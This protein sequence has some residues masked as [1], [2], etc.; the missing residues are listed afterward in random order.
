MKIMSIL[1]LYNLLRKNKETDS[2]D[3]K[4]AF[5]N[6]IF[7]QK[8]HTHALVDSGAKC[9]CI[10][11]DAFLKIPRSMIKGKAHRRKITLRSAGGNTLDVVGHY[12]L[13]FFIENREYEL[14]FAVVKNLTSEVLL[15]N[16][17]IVS[18]KVSI[19]GDGIGAVKV[20]IAHVS[21]TLDNDQ[22]GV[23]AVE[24]KDIPAYSIRPVK[25]K[26]ADKQD[27]KDREFTIFQTNEYNIEEMI[28]KL[29]AHGNTILMVIN[30]N[31]H[32]IRIQRN[33]KV[34]EAETWDEKHAARILQ[35][36]E[37][38][39][40][41]SISNKNI[42][43]KDIEKRWKLIAPLIDMTDI[44]KEQQKQYNKLFKEFVD[45]FSTNKFDLGKTTTIE[46]DI[47]LRNEEPIH[48]KQY[49]LGEQEEEM[50][51]EFVD[52]LLKCGAIRVSGS[53]YNSPIFMVN[54]KD[55]SPRVV[56]DY[57]KINMNTIPD[58]YIIRDCRDCI[59]II[60]KIKPEVFSTM[61]ITSSFWQVNLKEQ[62]RKATAFTLPGRGRFEW[63]T[64]PMGLH[65]S[66]STFA[67]M[68]DVILTGIKR[69]TCYIDDIIT[70][71]KTHEEQRDTLRQ[72]FT[73][74]RQHGLKIS[75]KKCKFAASKVDYLG[76]TI[77]KDGVR[78]KAEGIVKI[79]QFS[80]PTSVKKIK[81]F[82]GIC[83]YYRNWINNFARISAPLTE[84]TKQSNPWKNGDLPKDALKAFE[85]LRMALT[86]EPVTRFPDPKKRFYIYSDA[87]I[88]DQF[89]HGG[90][91]AVL[92]QEDDKVE[93]KLCPITYISKPLQK[94]E[95]N[96]SSYQAELH[97]ACWAVERFHPYVKNTNFVLFLDNRPL[98]NS[99]KME[100][101]AANKFQ[102]MLM[103]NPE[104]EVRHVD[105]A[106]NMMADL[107]SRTT[108]DQM[109][110]DQEEDNMTQEKDDQHRM[111]DDKTI[112][113]S[114][115]TKD[116]LDR[117]K[118]D[119]FCRQMY[120][121]L[122]FQEFPTDKKDRIRIQNFRDSCTLEEQG[123]IRRTI[124]RYGRI[125]KSV[126]I[127]PQDMQEEIL[128]AAHCTIWGG[129]AGI[130]KTNERILDQY[131]WPTLMKDIQEFVTSCKTCQ[132]AK[133]MPEKPAPLHS[134]Q[135]PD[136][137]NMRIHVD[138][139]TDLR[140]DEGYKNIL[141]ITDAFTKYA[142]VVPMKDKTAKA[143]A[144]AIFENW[145]C[146]FSCPQQIVSDRGLEFVNNTLKELCQLL[147][148]DRTM[149]SAFHPATNSAAESFNR[150]IKKYLS[151]MLEQN[152][153]EWAKWLPA[154]QLSYNTSVHK[155]TLNTPFAMTY[156]FDPK[157]P[158]F[159][160]DK[161]RIFY[162]Q[163][164]A[165]E[166]FKQLRNTFLNARK[167]SQEAIKKQ[168]EQFNKSAGE[169][170]SFEVGEKVLFQIYKTIHNSK[171][172]NKFMH[173]FVPATIV[174]KK[175]PETY[176]I[177]LNLA[178][179]THP[180]QVHVNLIRKWK[181]SSRYHS[182][183]INPSSRLQED[184]EEPQ[185]ET[186][187]SDGWSQLISQKNV[188]TQEE[189]NSFNHSSDE[190]NELQLPDLRISSDDEG[191]D[192]LPSPPIV[193]SYDSSPDPEIT[194]KDNSQVIR[195]N[196]N[197]K[198]RLSNNPP[199]NIEK[200]MNLA[201]RRRQSY[202]QNESTFEDRRQITPSPDL[203][204]N[205]QDPPNRGI[206]LALNRAADTLLP[207]IKEN[208]KK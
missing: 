77:D 150:T 182:Q 195:R 138:L 19:K 26:I 71:S 104:C 1:S 68:M 75:P 206:T 16:D 13:A 50:I 111:I 92:C 5:V 53:P 139:M 156:A 145:I 69:Y 167:N 191:V 158:Y 18:K 151:T 143:V 36:Q 42:K 7:D 207:P 197:S 48:S 185:Q 144:D 171:Q 59:D 110:I 155:T 86:K 133:S 28:T 41:A 35:P 63:I 15:G 83:N 113:A 91:G 177:V 21:E 180:K 98:V 116:I 188:N 179:D 45:V 119:L 78:P 137:P 178:K 105:E 74:L 32:N 163:T 94:H 169:L 201:K 106:Q 128:K 183:E 67:R 131:W 196:N 2:L 140:S 55:G 89:N 58:K 12:R 82:L 14:D 164:K 142:V 102:I 25:V 194:F 97:G 149:T 73:R 134:L 56:L 203:S 38:V 208:N 173:K 174:Q 87:A 123:M 44:P 52:K 39:E 66:S 129:H 147:R 46:H 108:M 95:K 31:P 29:D 176:M 198:R 118:G 109:E 93:G 40:I 80:P 192:Q 189:N 132:R 65:G 24:T 168:E 160:M 200:R 146:R 84:L 125:T 37:M 76:V 159:D 101:R 3:F 43:N 81:R 162:N 175:G 30:N 107:L 202:S 70:F 166:R 148:I 193:P 165:V 90:F 204:T 20:E 181:E 6:V 99:S 112:E 72:V 22:I 186:E 124:N 47:R 172:N 49:K 88:G 79:R 96:Y 23:Q 60:G 157:L 190:E 187:E 100:V 135:I 27:T 130:W 11:Y 115:R 103:E 4:R 136:A 152:T 54:K 57:R 117:Q 34:A 51:N 199:N 8:F 153:L 9:S 126:I 122:K 161:P 17:F 33:E 114:V 205:N 141:V 127:A 184:V 120:K 121:S 170:R 85:Q 154:L 61:D 64:M 10:S 62:A